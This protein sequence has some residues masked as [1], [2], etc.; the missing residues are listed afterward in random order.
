M[1]KATL[2][3]AKNATQTQVANYELTTEGYE[4][5]NLY[6]SYSWSSKLGESS[7][8]LQG[9]NLTDTEQRNHTSFIKDVAP[10]AGRSWKLG[11]RTTF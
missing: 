6:A 10:A 9:K 11:F 2:D 7:I 5:F 4:D 3:Y 1:N 8:Y